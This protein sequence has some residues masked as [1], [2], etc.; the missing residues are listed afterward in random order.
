MYYEEGKELNLEFEIQRSYMNVVEIIQH[1]SW[2]S[3]ANLL[4]TVDDNNLNHLYVALQIQKNQKF[5]A[6]LV[7][8]QT[9]LVLK[10]GELS[11]EQTGYVDLYTIYVYDDVSHNNQKLQ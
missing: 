4:T 11:F 5:V 2:G 10:S 7:N 6:T 3:S 8:H 9:C 1:H